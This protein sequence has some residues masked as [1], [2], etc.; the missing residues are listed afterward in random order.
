MS[1]NL[2]A[3]NPTS[4][5]GVRSTTPPQMILMKRDPTQN[6]VIG[7]ALGTQWLSYDPLN[8][9]QATQFVLSSVAQNVATWVPLNQGSDNPTLPNHSVALGTG[10]PGLNSTSPNATLGQPLVSNGTSADP[11]FGT[12]SVSGGGTGL[13]DIPQYAVICGGTTGEGPLQTVS[14][15]GVSTQVLTSNGTGLLPTWQNPTGGG[16]GN[17][18]PIAVQVFSTPG[19]FT[20]TPTSGMASCFVEVVGGGGGSGAGAFISAPAT[21]AGAGSGGYTRKFFLSSAIGASQPLVVG[22]GGAGGATDSALGI[23]GGDTTFGTGPILTGGGGQ[24]SSGPVLFDGSALGGT[25]GTAAGGDINVPG[26]CGAPSASTPY[27]GGFTTS[28]S[29][30]GTGGNAIYGSGGQ[31]AVT[32]DNIT[33][34]VAAKPG[35]GYGAGAGGGYTSG[36]GGGHFEPGASGANG[37]VIITEFGPF[38]PTPPS[39]PFTL[40]TIIF[41]TPGADS[42]TPSDGMFQC[43]VECLGG[44]GGSGGTGA[45]APGTNTATAGGGAGGYS[46]KLFD[47]ATIGASQLFF[48]GSGGTAGAINSDGGT[49]GT[50]TFG[51]FLSSLGG[52]GTPTSS[53]SIPHAGGL[54]GTATGGNINVTG[55][56]GSPSL[57]FS[58][59]AAA[60][61]GSGSGANSMYGAGGNGTTL[62]T[63]GSSPGN[64]GLG[65]GSG[66]AGAI[67]GFS[68]PLQPGAAGAQGVIIIT[69][70][71]S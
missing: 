44:G 50:S 4:Y 70:Y 19:S 57:V 1:S 11:S 2:T 28:T 55:S 29:I 7:Y 5:L 15:L 26:Q 60:T 12:A 56:A 17:G 49:G 52:V 43:I 53:N 39:S 67:C 66:A 68:N 41:D 46:K 32:T 31:G 54:G 71:I 63:A 45:N 3:N 9:G 40:N 18:G 36:T 23:A 25:G 62:A 37:V 6:D 20:Y 59:S 21:V 48:V 10:V 13:D 42:Y 35:L 58:P 16:G 51:A 14:G 30:N 8:P 61:G 47:A 65:Y 33:T 38:A 34:N 64:P 22:S 69:E 27:N 24:V